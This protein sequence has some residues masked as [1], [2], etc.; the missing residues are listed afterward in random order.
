MF[1]RRFQPA[2]AFPSREKHF[3]AF[4]VVILFACAEIATLLKI[5]IDNLTPLLRAFQNAT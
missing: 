1:R 5:A 4:T 3:A 2:N